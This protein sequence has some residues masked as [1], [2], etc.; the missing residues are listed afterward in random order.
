MSILP[1]NAIR[2]LIDDGLI[3]ID[4]FFPEFL[5]PNLYYCHLGNKFLIPNRDISKVDPL[6][7]ETNDIYKSFETNEP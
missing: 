2:K 1:D 7:M 6:I 3:I 5:G 4:P